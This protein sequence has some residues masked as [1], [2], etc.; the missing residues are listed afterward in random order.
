VIACG[1]SARF[2]TSWNAATPSSNEVPS[3]AA[4]PITHTAALAA[5]IEEFLDTIEGANRATR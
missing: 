1:G 3:T 2:H 4:I 5:V